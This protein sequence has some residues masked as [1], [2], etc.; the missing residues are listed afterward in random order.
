MTAYI[1][2]RLLATIPVMIL[3]ALVVF[4]LIHFAPGDP[5]AIIAGH[6]ATPEEVEAIREQLHG[7]SAEEKIAFWV[8]RRRSESL[9]KPAVSGPNG[10]DKAR[11]LFYL[12][13]FIV[14]FPIFLG[15]SLVIWFFATSCVANIVWVPI[16]LLA[17]WLSGSELIGIIVASAVVFSVIIGG[18]AR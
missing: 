11:R 1:I 17:N 15:G 3:V 5:A 8:E 7:L 10:P 6:E 18:P 16:Y 9:Q 13:R 12:L 14:V 4:G 2:R